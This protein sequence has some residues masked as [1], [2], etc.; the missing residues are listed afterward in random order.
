VSAVPAIEVEGLRRSY[1]ELTAVDGVSF[2]ITE[3]TCT[4]LL[5]PN[6]AG[7]TTTVEILEGY[8]RRDAGEVRV[9]GEDPVRAGRAWRERLG[10]V[11]QDCSDLLELTV[12]ECV[13]YFSTLY[14][15]PRG[16]HAVIALVG[17]TEKAHAR[18]KTLSGGQRR[19]LDVGLG[20]VGDPE[21]LFLDEPTTGFDPEARRAFW[22]LIGVLK[23]EGTTI[24]LTTHYMEEADALAD[25]VI[26]V[27][28]GKVV[29]DAPP[30]ELGA[31]GDDESI[32]RWFEHGAA[33]ERTTSS[34][35]SLIV[36]LHRQR[37]GELEGLEVRRPS[38]ED[39]YLRLVDEEPPT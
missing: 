4:A 39:V 28:R 16:A 31:R 18:V 26:V 27:N 7:K 1:G 35:T 33:V 6:G 3:G 36:E 29:A 8:R 24:L 23:S 34:P 13:G 37:G 2:S 14:P 9:L 19:R 5:G 30:K 15:R 21:I 32:V 12:A 17:L 10:I 11:P 38:L 22:Q 25:R 20:I